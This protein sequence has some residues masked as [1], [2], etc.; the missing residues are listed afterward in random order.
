MHEK[1]GRQ[2]ETPATPP[3]SHPCHHQAHSKGP[4]VALGCQPG[5][6]AR[7]SYTRHL[8]LR[9]SRSLARYEAASMGIVPQTL[10]LHFFDA[11]Q[12]DSPSE[13]DLKLAYRFKYKFSHMQT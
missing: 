10:A 3:K 6:P 11:A 2:T 13:R 4:Y 12:L 9:H 5:E 7:A 1:P 8:T